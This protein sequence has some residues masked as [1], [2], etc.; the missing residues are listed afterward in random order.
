M[1]P[2]VKSFKCGEF[3]WLVYYLFPDGRIATQFVAR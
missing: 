2:I 1:V 3:G